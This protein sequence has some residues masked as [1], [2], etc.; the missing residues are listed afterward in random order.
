MSVERFEACISH[1]ETRNWRVPAGP[2]I[3]SETLK[4][5]YSEEKGDF[6]DQSFDLEWKDHLK[7]YFLGLFSLEDWNT[8]GKKGTRRETVTFSCK[9]HETWGSKIESCSFNSV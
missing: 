1:V 9:Q 3:Q 7:K 2:I 8:H 5:D 4:V 6:F